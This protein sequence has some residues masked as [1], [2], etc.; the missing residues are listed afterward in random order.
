ML[1]SEK[2]IVSSKMSKSYMFQYFLLLFLKGK[3]FSTMGQRLAAS[4]KMVLQYSLRMSG[5]LA[6]HHEG[7]GE[8]DSL[9]LVYCITVN[10]YSILKNYI[11]VEGF[12]DKVHAS[13]VTHA[14]E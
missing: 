5:V 14:E 1:R 9:K 8:Q 6:V 2:E 3:F 13:R 4:C 12:M 10:Y 11:S 7:T